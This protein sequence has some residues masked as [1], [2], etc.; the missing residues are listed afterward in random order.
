MLCYP[1]SGPQHGTRYRPWL[2]LTMAVV[3]LLL[4][5]GQWWYLS[6]SGWLQDAM[7]WFSTGRLYVDPGQR[8]FNPVQIWSSV[9]FHR[10]W[11]Q[12][13]PVVWVWIAVSSSLE[14]EWGF[15]R[16][17]CLYVVIA[18]ISASLLLIARSA[19]PG[20]G[21]VPLVM[22]AAGALN[23]VKPEQR[24]Y[25]GLWY[26]VPWSLA[27][28]QLSAHVFVVVGIWLSYEVLRVIIDQRQLMSML[29]T[30]SVMFLSASTSYLFAS[31]LF[32][33]KGSANLQLI[34]DIA[35]G[36]QPLDRLEQALP[37]T[38]NISLDLMAQITQ[39]CLSEQRHDVARIVA[40]YLALREPEHPS[41]AVLRSFLQGATESGDSA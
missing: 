1:R 3:A 7:S 14:R 10:D 20:F 15:L 24:L 28:R 17:L 31:L 2:S 11:W 32:V 9:F 40:T 37:K 21:L 18:P 33:P 4:F 25:F 6:L 5:S 8:F 34:T 16:L 12:L 36:V 26:L 27:W 22:A 39:R 35:H 23:A 19:H 13:I 38:E 41:L 29:I 30:L